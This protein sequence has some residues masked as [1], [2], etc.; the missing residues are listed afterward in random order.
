MMPPILR[1]SAAPLWLLTALVAACAELPTDTDGLSEVL[2]VLAPP[3]GLEFSGELRLGVVPAAPAI[4]VGS[5]EGFEVRDGVTGATIMSGTNETVTVT[6]VDQSLPGK[7]S[8][9]MLTRP[10]VT[11]EER[12]AYVALAAEREEALHKGFVT[13]AAE[14]AGCWNVYLG[15]LGLSTSSTTRTQFRMLATQQGLA[16][17]ADPWF[18]ITTVTVSKGFKIVKGTSSV[19]TPNFVKVHPVA[20]R[21]KVAD[22]EV[23]GQVEVFR[24]AAG[25]LTAVNAVPL[26]QYLRRVVPMVLPPDAY[27]TA[28]AQKAQAVAERTRALYNVGRHAAEGFDFYPGEFQ[29]YGEADVEHE[30]SNAAI[31]ATAGMVATF[32]GQLIDTPY[33]PSSGGW[34]ANSED[35]FDPVVAY[36]RGI[37]ESQLPWGLEKKLSL[38]MFSRSGAT[39]LRTVLKNERGVWSRFNLWKVDWSRAEMAAALSATF[40]VPVGDVTAVRVVERGAYARVRRVEFDTDVGTLVAEKNDIRTKLPYLTVEGEWEPLSSTLFFMVP[41]ID[42][43]QV[44]GWRV[45]GAG[46]GHG[47]GMSQIGAVMM[48]DLGT[49]FATILSTYYTGVTV[50]ARD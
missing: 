3:T 29:P 15:D 7:T 31:D 50:E 16:T 22:K 21:T 39:D 27:G 20:G 9:R 32:E 43:E 35:V 12:D 10:C 37:S 45:Y 46:L 42:S 24:N 49:D 25:T 40:G 48:S 47:V 30:V 13:Y 36:L 33:H 19:T 41:L 44:T 8:F 11:V 14:S 2:P 17:H 4:D 38:E 28:E 1:Q 18:R 6:Y 26:E 23:D 34:T 5:S